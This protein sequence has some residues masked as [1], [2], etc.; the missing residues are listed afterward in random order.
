MS[1]GPEERTPSAIGGHVAADFR[2]SVESI[3]ARGR[4]L[5]ER[6]SI[7]SLREVHARALEQIEVLR[8]AWADPWFGWLQVDEDGQERV[9]RVGQIHCP[10]V[11]IVSWRHPLGKIFYELEPGE[12]YDREGG[13]ELIAGTVLARAR[14]HQRRHVVHHVRWEDEQG[15]L[16]LARLSDGDFD[17]EEVAQ[18]LNRSGTLPSIQAWLTREQ[19]RFI[20]QAHDRPLILQGKAGSGKTTVALHRLSWLCAPQPRPDGTVDRPLVQA[21][22][23]LIVMFNRALCQFVEE[24]LASLE[25]SK[26]TLRTFHAWALETLRVV[27][28]GEL[29]ISTTALPG[30]REASE[31]K[32]HVGVLAAIDAYVAEQTDRME[33]WL[34][35]QLGPLDGAAWLA[36]YQRGTAPVLRRL[37]ELRDQARHARNAEADPARH[38]RLAG[39]YDVFSRAAER[40]ALYKED[41]RRVLTDPEGLSRHLRGI[42]RPTLE[43][44]ARY[45]DAL[46]REGATGQR[47]VGSAVDFDDLAL[48]LRLMQVKLGGLPRA[49][50]EAFL[51]DHLLVDEA[52]DFGAVQLRVLLDAVSSRTGVT[53][54]GDVNQKILPDVHFIGWQAL[55]KEL[56]LGGFEV[57]QLEVGHRSTGPIVRLAD[58]IAEMA[59]DADGRPGPPPLDLMTASETETWNTIAHLIKRRMA[60]ANDAHICVVASSIDRARRIQQSLNTILESTV[61]LGHNQSFTFAPGVTVTN[62]HQV[63][64]LEFDTVIVLDPTP[65]AYPP[66]DEGRRALYVVASR[67]QERLVFVGHEPRSPLIEALVEEGLLRRASAGLERQD[68]AGWS[69]TSS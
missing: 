42:E 61:R 31:V 29:T 51:Y 9:Y 7:A 6:A 53:I 4:Q 28:R 33:G 26:A 65:D 49:S 52:Q 35:E 41:L 58:R 43:A 10:D 38:K 16:A 15:E 66:T 55:A 39:V 63:K 2:Q 56:G 50:D 23:I 25:L 60:D 47:R 62:R 34:G 19:F 68:A 57:A 40:M 8:K 30:A 37:R 18:A 59:P 54:V 32:A 44:A 67:A 1:T 3:T 20:A 45:Q 69:D 21:D 11:G 13:R 17:L 14:I 22:N 48:L 46:Q 36:R 24:S 64:G 12:D 5:G 27:Y